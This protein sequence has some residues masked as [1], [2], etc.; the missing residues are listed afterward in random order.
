MTQAQ[1]DPIRGA[2]DR[3]AKMQDAVAGF[4]SRIATLRRE[5]ALT[6]GG[7]K[8]RL[9]IEIAS[10]AAQR[11]GAVELVAEAANRQAEAEAARDATIKATSANLGKHASECSQAA[12][13]VDDAIGTLGGAL[14]DLQGALAPLAEAGFV[15]DGRIGGHVI[16]A[17][18]KR[19][20]AGR[21]G[22]IAAR[23]ATM[24]E[25]IELTLS[26]ARQNA[27]RMQTRGAA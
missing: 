8:R 3:V 27:A 14:D 13:R 25:K 4:D 5:L 15:A 6:K 7:D 26:S 2:K 20:L 17:A 22:D 19:G 12:R 21:F 11:E 23:E 18:V 24:A 1:I 9:E 10:L 16:L